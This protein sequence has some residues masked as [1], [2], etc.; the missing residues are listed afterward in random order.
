MG[1]DGR[2]KLYI[3]KSAN[4][5]DRSRVVRFGNLRI[6]AEEGLICIELVEIRDKDKESPR[7]SQM[8]PKV[9]ESRL[10]DMFKSAEGLVNGKSDLADLRRVAQDV[11]D[12]IQVAREQEESLESK[13][14]VSVRMQS[15]LYLP[16]V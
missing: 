11:T 8:R 1:K 2:S 12:L 14:P 9:A 3:P 13:R 10:R 4:H 6:W 16:G 5:C 7:V 15:K